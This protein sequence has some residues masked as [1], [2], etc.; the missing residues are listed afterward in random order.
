MKYKKLSTKKAEK[1]I[2][3]IRK[4]VGYGGSSPIFDTSKMPTN[5]MEQ[6]PSGDEDII[7]LQEIMDTEII[8]WHKQASS[9]L[10][11]GVG[12]YFVRVTQ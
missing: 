5:V 3:S 7:S 1:I 10:W 4:K 6:K 12:D 11:W 2:S 9:G 8:R